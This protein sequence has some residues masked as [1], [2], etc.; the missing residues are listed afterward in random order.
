MD[1]H[2]LAILLRDESKTL[3]LVEPLHSTAS[4][5]KLLL[6]RV[7]RPFALPTIRAAAYARSRRPALRRR[8]GDKQKRQGASLAKS[9]VSTPSS[10][11]DAGTI[12]HRR[13]T[14]NH[15]LRRPGGVGGPGDVGLCQSLGT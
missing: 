8:V 4:H 15:S 12:P 10:T 6:C 7:R 1:E 5:M 2:V 9:N 13:P 11:E 3:G 14:C